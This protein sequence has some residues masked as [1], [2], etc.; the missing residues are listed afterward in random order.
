MII[1]DKI[2]EQKLQHYSNRETAISEN[3]DKY[4]YLRGEE[5]FFQSKTNNTARF[6]K[7]AY[8]HL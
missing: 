2:R 7:F 8:S 4:E 5:I 3:I 6:A 1:D